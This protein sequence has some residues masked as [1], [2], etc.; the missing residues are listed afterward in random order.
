M[1]LISHRGNLNGKNIERENSPKY[2]EEAIQ[3]LYFVEID[4]WFI[5]NTFY[6]GHD[7]PK[8]E[9]TL[10]W[11]KKN[12]LYLILHCK[13][14]EALLA[15]KSSYKCFFHDYDDCVLMSNVFWIWTYPGKKLTADSIAVLPETVKDW[16]ISNCAG[17]CSDVIEKYA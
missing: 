12:R 7:E 16:D 14:V 6:L 15:L 1:I 11:I 8:Y 9:V 5:D 10:D 2:I 4:I 17:V 13:N 3:K